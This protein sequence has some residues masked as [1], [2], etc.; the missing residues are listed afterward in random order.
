RYLGSVGLSDINLGHGTA[1]LGYWVRASEVG[2]GL[3]ST[4]AAAVVDAGFEHLE[5]VRIEVMTAVENMASRRVAEK[6]G[7]VLEGALRKR[8]VLEGEPVDCALY[9]VVR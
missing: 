7:A 6:L 2:R 4:A 1:A 9:S 5:L 3:A 8:Q